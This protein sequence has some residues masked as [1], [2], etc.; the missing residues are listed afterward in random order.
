[1]PPKRTTAA[2][3]KS[4][5]RGRPA[6]RS[7]SPAKRKAKTKLEKCAAEKKVLAEKVV[8]AEKKT[9]AARKVCGKSE[10]RVKA[11]SAWKPKGNYIVWYSLNIGQFY[12]KGSGMKLGDAAKEAGAAWRA[13]PLEERVQYQAV[14]AVCPNA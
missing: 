11:A 10:S 7:V 9:R 8:V 4:P 3:K 6:T 1:M 12:V 13:M 14:G 5:G 2:A